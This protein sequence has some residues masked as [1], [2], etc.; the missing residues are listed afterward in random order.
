[1][2]KSAKYNIIILL[3][4]VHYLLFIVDCSYGQGW[5]RYRKEFSISLGASNLLGDL[6]GANTIGT[7]GMLDFDF[8]S[9]RPAMNIGYSYKL[10]Q[11][12]IVKT[13]FTYGEIY[14]NDAYTDELWRNHRNLMFRS[15]ITQLHTQL[16]YYIIREKEGHK[17]NIEGVKGWR[18][19]KI[20]S[21]FF[22]GVGG[23]YYKPKAKYTGPDMIS[24]H[25]KVY[26]MSSYRG[27]WYDLKSYHTE[28]EG[29]VLTRPNYSPVQL[30]IPFGIGFKYAIKK[31]LAVGIE[32]GIYKTFTDYVDDCSTT[33]FDDDYLLKN[34]GPLGWW[35]AN[36]HKADWGGLNAST[37]APGQ[38]RGNPREKDA[39]MFAF[40]SLYYTIPSGR[41]VVPLF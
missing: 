15:S 41:F 14:G 29:V 16:E 38:Q 20:S 11:R 23:F 21:Y 8:P 12:F 40:V 13:N 26:D 32:Y 37:T 9:I 27:K 6:G 22:V 24:I 17:Y 19:I 3:I 31:N 1:M 35:F 2:T 7:H 33:Y 34:Y 30:S 39:Y 28:G 4:I 10:S 18:N 5:K 25:G 36:P